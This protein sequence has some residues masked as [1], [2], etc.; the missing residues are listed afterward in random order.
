MQNSI[1]EDDFIKNISIEAVAVWDTVGSLGI[2]DFEFDDNRA[3]IRDGFAF[4]DNAL[5][6]KVK[7]GFHAVALDEMRLLFTPTLW[8]KREGIQQQLFVGTHADVGGGYKEA[9]L[10]DIALRWMIDVLGDAKVGIQFMETAANIKGDV[11]AIAHK[12]WA[13]LVGVAGKLGA[14]DFKKLAQDGTLQVHV[15]VQERKALNAFVQY[16]SATAGKYNPTN[17]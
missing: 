14:R 11:A 8:D 15:S 3:E 17:Y 1:D 12:E 4:A 7:R 10:S 5:N 9:G 6:P 13:K 2:P 16:A